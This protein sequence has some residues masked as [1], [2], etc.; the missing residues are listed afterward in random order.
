MK[1]RPPGATLEGRP[2]GVGSERDLDIF[3]V[4]LLLLDLFGGARD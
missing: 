4:F 3:N 1:A 2:L